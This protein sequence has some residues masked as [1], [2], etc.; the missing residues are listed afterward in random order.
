V[1]YHSERLVAIHHPTK[2][3]KFVRKIAL[4][5]SY[6]YTVLLYGAFK[7]RVNGVLN[8]DRVARFSATAMPFPANENV[9][10]R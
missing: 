7:E 5:P 8:E 10:F 9:D 1:D 6:Y 3:K 4:K 2:R